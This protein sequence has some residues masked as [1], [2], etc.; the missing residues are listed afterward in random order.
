L[1][2]GLARYGD[3]RWIQILADE[4]GLL[5]QPLVRCKQQVTVGPATDTWTAWVADAKAGS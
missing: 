5:V 3:E 1:G 2:L 4:P